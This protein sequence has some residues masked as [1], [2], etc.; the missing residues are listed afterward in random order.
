MSK[1][2]IAKLQPWYHIPRPQCDALIGRKKDQCL[3]SARYVGEDREIYLCQIHA[4]MVDF[5]VKPIR[6]NRID[7]R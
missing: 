2:R 5:P 6:A 3:F 7:L 4:D 1:P